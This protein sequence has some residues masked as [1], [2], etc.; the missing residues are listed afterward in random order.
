M[1]DIIIVGAGPAGLTAAI[2]TS[3]RGLKTLVVSMGIGG[4]ANEARKVENYPGCL[5]AAEGAD[6]M[7]KFFEQAKKFGAEFKFEEAVDLK[8][9]NNNFLVRTG[10]GEYEARAVILG[11]G[12]TPRRLGAP[13][14]KELTGKGVSY[15]AICDAPFYKNKI[16][17]VAGGG[18]AAAE[19]ALHLAAFAKKVFLLQRGEK[20]QAETV[21]LQQIKKTKNI[22]IIYKKLVK[23][24]KGGKKVEAIVLIGADG[25]DNP[26]KLAVDGIFIE[27]GSE[28]KTA[29]ISRTVKLNKK[30][31]IIIDKKGA[32]SC[33]GIFAAGDITDIGF[34][35][36]VIAAGEGAK[37]G[38]S[39]MQ[40]LQ[41]MQ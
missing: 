6:L 41:K 30:Q 17:A 5:E 27:I 24:I 40:Y 33:P 13:G 8:K 25:K 2:Y 3:R 35:Q 29:W 10:S 22:E 20:L 39:A 14:E 18:N 26:Q 15:C 12:L 38:L 19:A 32:T 7:L 21:F 31:E 4:Q 28:P 37:A 11:F 36:I 9:K 16:V 23:E 34:R 1:Y